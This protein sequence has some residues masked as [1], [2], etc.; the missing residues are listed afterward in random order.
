MNSGIIGKC[1]SCGW[2]DDRWWLNGELK[3][4]RCGTLIVLHVVEHLGMQ[5]RRV[6]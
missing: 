6:K 3:C 2:E 4:R 5:S 1:P